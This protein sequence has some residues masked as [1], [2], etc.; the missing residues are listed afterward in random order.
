MAGAGADR[1]VLTA[2]LVGGLALAPVLM[3]LL[4]VWYRKRSQSA[5]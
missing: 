5:A 2:L 1:T 4:W 3:R